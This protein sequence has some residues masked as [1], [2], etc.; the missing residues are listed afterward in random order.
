MNELKEKSI[1]L[2][3]I[4]D[5]NIEKNININEQEKFKS[6]CNKNAIL[7]LAILLINLFYFAFFVFFGIYLL[8]NPNV[9]QGRNID[10]YFNNYCQKNQNGT[11]YD[12]VCTNKYFKY[13]YKKKKFIWVMTDGTAYDELVELHKLHK[14]K[15][16]TSFRV[17]GD[18]F[19]LTNELHQA[20]ITGKRNRNFFGS[21]IEFDNLLQQAKNS[22]MK[23]NYRGWTYP[24]PGIIGENKGGIKDGKFFNKK[25]I[26][27]GREFLNFYSFCNFTN[28]FPFLKLYFDTY[29]KSDHLKNS[30]YNYSTEVKDLLKR[31][32][33]HNYHLE[34][35]ISKDIFFENLDEFFE[36]HPIDLFNE[37]ISECL[38]KSF[39]WNP[40]DNISVLYYTTELDHFNHMFG[41][42]HGYAIVSSYLTEKMIFNLMNWTDENPDYALI[43]TTDHGGQDFYG[44]DFIRNHGEDVPG[45]EGIFYIYT[46]ELKDNYD[47]LN[48]KEKYIDIVDESAIIPQ[49]LYDINI[50]IYSDGIPYS[51]VN[52][53]ILAYSALKAK[54]IQ[55]IYLIDNYISKY[56][57]KY[58]KLL[59]IKKELNESLSQF[60]FIKN[61]YFNNDTNS[62]KKLFKNLINENLENIKKQQKKVSKKI[63]RKNR[64]FEN[65]II[66]VLILLFSLIKSVI[67]FYYLTKQIFNEYYTFLSNKPIKNILHIIIICITII[68]IIL[69]FLIPYIFVNVS[70]SNKLAF[71]VVGPL[72]CSMIN[73]IIVFL[74]FRPKKI[75]DYKYK[76]KLYYFIFALFGIFFFTIFTHYSY[77][78]HSIKEYYSRYGKGRISNIVIIYPMYIGEIIYEM[79]KYKKLFFYFGGQRKIK[80]LYVMIILN[81][82][83]VLFI[84]IQDMTANLYHTGQR[85]L[86][87]IANFIDFILFLIYVLFSNFLLF[88]E[89]DQQLNVENSLDEKS[90]NAL[91][92]SN[93]EESINNLN[94]QANMIEN[95]ENIE[96][97][98]EKIDNK[99][100]KIP[101]NIG[102]KEKIK[103]CSV[104]GFPCKKLCLINLCFWLSDESE[105]LYLVLLFIPFLEYFDYLADFF[106]TKIID[107][108]FFPDK[109][110]YP[111]STRINLDNTQ[112][113]S[114]YLTNTNSMKKKNKPADIY[115]SSFIF[116]ILAQ[117]SIL[118]L[119]HIIF[120]LTQR[121]YEYCFST[122]QG[123]KVIFARFLKSLVDYVGKYKFSFVVIG[124]IVTRRQLI[125]NKKL[126]N[127]TIV[128]TFP[129]ILLFVR[130][131]FNLILFSAFTLVN[132]DNDVFI[133]LDM[134]CF[135][136]LFLEAVDICGLIISKIIY[137]IYKLA[138][139]NFKEI[140]LVYS[141]VYNQD[142]L[143]ENWK[144]KVN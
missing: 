59:N 115:I 101:K 57:S 135:I 143:N 106:Y 137:L 30:Y 65:I 24:I 74:I 43:I 14:Y 19:K 38:G 61:N 8:M 99:D 116:F 10:E 98:F 93:N 136:D 132:V 34:P 54:E 127:F 117:N 73:I 131:S 139:P 6:K 11:Y 13:E 16:T 85:L 47:S 111:L 130:I 22:K 64:T 52:D 82:L 28:P 12:L 3:K 91:N 56:G 75:F 37:N 23:I 2:P 21:N 94:C 95:I 15:I 69:P 105:R 5:N 4:N 107:I 44:E 140:I 32:T 67:E 53:N 31:S 62:S 113:S 50:P 87:I 138:L 58:N 89:I 92:F 63:R 122:R 49:I 81:F 51:I 55:L 83:F 129:R 133:H 33:D 144:Q 119:N 96:N 72:I 9:F 18:N 79:V 35:N 40:D 123:Q 102:S 109:P 66:F 27:D 108:V 7:F 71:L 134:Y 36:E 103:I 90:S 68:L 17:V 42:R 141:S 100:N 104:N 118:H 76:N 29:Q 88:T 48:V 78:F 121:S 26:D 126:K 39:E 86:N 142:L 84:F 77:C 110:N 125:I 20:K 128:Y 1:S 41:K 112:N 45:N 46:K 25:F 120:L 80:V 70:M 124:Y 114:N 97:N 60:E